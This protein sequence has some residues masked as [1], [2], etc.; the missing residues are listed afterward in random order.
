VKFNR[1]IFQLLIGNIENH[2]RSQELH[3]KENLKQQGNGRIK[4][5]KTGAQVKQNE[6]LFVE[7]E[8]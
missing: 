5:Y 6:V 7:Q 1:Y 2:L 8:S 3:I 4:N